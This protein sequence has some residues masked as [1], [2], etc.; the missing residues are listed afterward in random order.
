[1]RK[2]KTWLMACGLG[3]ALVLSVGCGDD[4][5][6]N[7]T[8]DN[9]NQNQ[10][11]TTTVTL[12]TP[13]D[14]EALAG[15]VTVELELEG[16]AEEVMLDVGGEIV[17]TQTATEGTLSFD[18]DTTAGD[19]GVMD[20]QVIA[21][22]GGAVVAQS[23]VISV[24]VDNTAP[25][26]TLEGVE[27][28]YVYQGQVTLTATVDDPNGTDV[29][30]LMV[31]GEEVDRSESAPHELS[32]DPTGLPDGAVEM[33]LVTADSLENTTEVNLDGVVVL[34][35]QV[36][37]FDDGDGSGMFFI[38]EDYTPGMEVHHKYHWTMPAGIT[39]I[40]AVAQWEE[41]GW[42]LEVATGS[43]TCPHSGVSYGGDEAEGHQV[44]YHHEAAD[45]SADNYPEETHFV[46]VGEAST[47]DL[48]QR[49]G[50]GTNF[51][52][53]AVIY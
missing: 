46:H 41:P 5:G 50:E 43:G 35:G 52:L 32:W 47:M 9:Q 8:N 29:L 49:T 24:E 14:G 53:V 30:M 45:L 7:G 21:A 2:L 19:D 33:R 16:D 11:S 40:M 13:A 20:V 27:R 48:T 22:A 1:M 39:E 15:T 4:D 34:Q 51:W 44:V 38:P 6:G 42:A 37:A 31:D 26:V 3:A 23:D 28:P 17:D 12:V 10:N 18:W 25:V 36:V